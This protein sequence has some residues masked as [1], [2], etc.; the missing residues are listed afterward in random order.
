MVDYLGYPTN[1]GFIEGT[2]SPEA[3]G[4]DG[5]ALDVLVLGD[6]VDRAERVVVRPL[7]V[8]R[9]L[10]QVRSTTKLI[11]TQMNG[12]FSSMKSMSE[13]RQKYPGVLE[14]LALWFGNYKRQGGLEMLEWGDERLAR[15]LI[16][17][18]VCEYARY[19]GTTDAEY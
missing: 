14:I 11:A 6:Q 17:E 19:H 18:A 5:D 2:L 1:Y 16:S 10:D 15:N 8:L 9:L 12:P 7:A 3:K 13:L 4:G